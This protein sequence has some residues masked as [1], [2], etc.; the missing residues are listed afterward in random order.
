M[1]GA[2]NPD[3][4]FLHQILSISLWKSEDKGCVFGEKEKYKVD[5]YPVNIKG[6]ILGPKVNT[7]YWNYP[8]WLGRES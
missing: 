2:S 4:F 6:I 1:Q 7:F 3:K 5:N 8:V